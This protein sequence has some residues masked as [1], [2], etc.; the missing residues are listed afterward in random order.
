MSMSYADLFIT[1]TSEKLLEECIDQNGKLDQKKFDR[2]LSQAIHDEL[3]I[4]YGK[5]QEVQQGH[6]EFVNKMLT[7]EDIRLNIAKKDREK[8]NLQLKEELIK[9]NHVK[10]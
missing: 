10:T 9:L 1:L 3:N 6:K 8:L 4:V 5:L 2:K 7:R